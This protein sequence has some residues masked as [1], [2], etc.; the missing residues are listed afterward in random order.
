MARPIAPRAYRARLLFG[1]TARSSIALLAAFVA[2][3]VVG[4]GNVGAQSLNIAL[5]AAVGSCVTQ[6]G[7]VYPQ[8]VSL[9]TA[10]GHT[11]T[12]VSGADID[13]PAE[14]GSYDVVVFGA[15]NFE[16]DW[17]WPSFDAQLGPYVSGGGGL[18]VTGW[19]AHYA[20]TN[21]KSETYPGLEAVL[22]FVKGTNFLN[23][24]TVVVLSSHPITDG[25]ANFPNPQ[26]DNH[27]GGPKSG[28]TVLTRNGSTDNGAAW[29][30]GSGRVVYLGPTYLANWSGY[31]NEAL[32][33]GSTPDAQ[34]LFL[35]SIEWAGS[36]AVGAVPVPAAA[37]WVLVVLAGIW[38]VAIQ[39]RLRHRSERHLLRPTRSR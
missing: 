29:E 37:L 17:D 20:A 19:A 35:R 7:D 13:T 22:P 12:V 38:V 15:G 14:I 3:Y 34:E 21:P 27:G 6:T 25:L 23:G 39:W 31:D 18:V 24:G 26:F 30:L 2:L 36:G 8:V 32:L 5:E 4:V 33:D 9:L 1:T 28:A 16:C 11:A 10:R